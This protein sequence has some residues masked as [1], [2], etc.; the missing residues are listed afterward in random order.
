MIGSLVR[1]SGFEDIEFQAELCTSGSLQGVLAGS[2]YNRAWAVHRVMSESFE[3]LFMDRF[4]YE[5]KPDIPDELTKLVVDPQLQNIYQPLR[6][7]IDRLSEEYT[8]VNL[9]KMH[10][11]ERLGKLHSSGSC[12]WI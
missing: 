12:T 2:H 6:K 7:A 5:R 9:E 3:R 4:L 1:E 8:V 10:I 11:Q